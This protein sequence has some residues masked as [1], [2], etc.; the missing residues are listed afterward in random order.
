MNQASEPINPE[1]PKWVP[2]TFDPAE[3]T[4]EEVGCHLYSLAKAISLGD[5][6]AIAEIERLL[7]SG[8]KA[9]LVLFAHQNQT[10]QDLAERLEAEFGAHVGSH[11]PSGLY[12]QVTMPRQE[13]DRLR[14]TLRVDCGYFLRER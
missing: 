1:V 3:L 2:L 7:K 5:Q 9:E 14:E 10:P 12:V 13:L 11:T 8:L 6:R 4:G